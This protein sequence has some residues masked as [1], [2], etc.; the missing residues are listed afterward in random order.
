[1]PILVLLKESLEK[2]EIRG[3]NTGIDRSFR[4]IRSN[5][6]RRELCP[7]TDQ[8]IPHSPPT[9]QQSGLPKRSSNKPFTSICVKKY[10]V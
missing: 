6:K 3:D 8:S 7:Q 5:S 9:Q 10:A 2:E 1:M 4:T